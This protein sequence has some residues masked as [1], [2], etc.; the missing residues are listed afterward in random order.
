MTESVTSYSLN[1]SGYSNYRVDTTL[2]ILSATCNMFVSSSSSCSLVNSQ[3]TQ[4]SKR[5]QQ[6]NSLTS[7]LTLHCLLLE[8]MCTKT[9]EHDV[10]RDFQH[11]LD[12]AAT[13]LDVFNDLIFDLGLLCC[14]CFMCH[15]AVFS[16]AGLIMR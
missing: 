11:F 8:N 4:N 2:N 7:C 10:S 14:S 9:E 13:K 12:S 5:L 15:A 1:S 6:L 3:L 16:Q